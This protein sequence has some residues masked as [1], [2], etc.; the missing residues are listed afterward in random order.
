MFSKNSTSKVFQ[1]YKIQ[2]LSCALNA[3][4]VKLTNKIIVTLTF[5]KVTSLFIVIVGELVILEDQ[6]IQ[7]DGLFRRCIVFQGG[8]VRIF[9][10]Y[11][12]NLTLKNSFD[13]TTQNFL[14]IATG[15]YGGLW[16]FDGWNN[17]NFVTEEIK[18]PK[19]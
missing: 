10:G 9:Q 8:I 16:A 4:S 15:F 12:D 17:L 6:E 14:V 1:F 18:N 13:G 19:R 3:Y 11:T 7:I 2:V 5:A